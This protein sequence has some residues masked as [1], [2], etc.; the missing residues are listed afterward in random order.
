MP[1]TLRAFDSQKDWTGCTWSVPSIDELANAIA[2][3]ATG[4]A[5]H[6]AE[7]LHSV[8]LA[9]M[10][11]SKGAQRE[12]VRLLT[13]TGNVAHRDGWMFQ[14]MSWLAAQKRAPGALMNTPHL[15][16]AH[17]GLDGL[18]VVIDGAGKVTA[19]IIF[20]DKATV[21]PRQMVVN[22]V[23]PEFAK[24][25]QGEY[26]N[27]IAHDVTQLLSN[28]SH[29]NPREAV[30]NIMWNQVRRYRLSITDKQSTAASHEK[31][32]D[33]YAKYVPGK[34]E[35]RRAEVFEVAD[36]RNWMEQVAS[37]AKAKASA[38]STTD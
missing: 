28:A 32:F 26:Q 31:L 8:G 37:C 17:K 19:V 29:V 36:L 22:K 16:H 10:P 5:Y 13:A 24:F 35:R 21:N 27:L 15:I 1:I 11:T 20:E 30:V 34:R 7:I 38:L 2:I 23:W 14:V 6:V 4:Q 25:E 3:V 9:A 33:G 18:Q 12:A